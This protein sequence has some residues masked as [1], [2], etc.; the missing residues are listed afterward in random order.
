[1]SEI[2]VNTPKGDII[3]SKLFFF[4]QSGQGLNIVLLLC[5]LVY[6][7]LRVKELGITSTLE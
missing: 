5:V 3:L 4:F 6:I 1:M 7:G 2:F